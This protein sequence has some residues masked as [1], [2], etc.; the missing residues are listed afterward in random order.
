MPHTHLERLATISASQ[1]EEHFRDLHPIVALVSATRL[2]QFLEREGLI[3][4]EHRALCASIIRKALPSLENS[5]GHDPANLPSLHGIEQTKESEPRVP[6][7]QSM[8]AGVSTPATVHDK[9]EDALS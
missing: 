7:A 8:A 3:L 6:L 4:H 2:L 1:V 9:H 5:P